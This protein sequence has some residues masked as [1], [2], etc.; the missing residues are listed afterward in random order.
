V[1]NVKEIP[2]A[3]IDNYN[4]LVAPLLAKY[5]GYN[6][7][8]FILPIL[9]GATSWLSGWIMQKGQPKN[10]A[11][12]SMNTTMKWMMPAVSVFACLSSNAAFAVY[13]VM[14]NLLTT[15]TTYLINKALNKTND[16][17]EQVK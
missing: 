15:G 17:K 1:E 7:G 13:W 5:E 8:W 16:Q 2:Q 4:N 14:S 10:D 11:T 6:N 3:S 9:A 12:Q